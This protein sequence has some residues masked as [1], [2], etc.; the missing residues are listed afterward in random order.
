MQR[1]LRQKFP[2]IPVEIEYMWPGLI[3]VSKDFLPLTGQTDGKNEKKKGVY[4]ISGAAGLPWAAAL[5]QYIAEKITHGRD[6]FDADF[7]AVRTYPVPNAVQ[8]VLTKP[9]SFA[10]SHGVVKYFNNSELRNSC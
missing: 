6:D 4:Y 8:T 7:T 3:G 5:A 10:I 9:V 2:D 1:Y